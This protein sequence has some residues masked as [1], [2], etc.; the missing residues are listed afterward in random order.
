MIC[1]YRWHVLHSKFIRDERIERLERDSSTIALYSSFDWKADVILFITGYLMNSSLEIQSLSSSAFSLHRWSF[2]VSK[3]ARWFA[4]RMSKKIS[5]T[6]R[7]NWWLHKTS[8]LEHDNETRTNRKMTKR[9]RDRKEK[10]TDDN[11][12]LYRIIIGRFVQSIATRMT[13]L[14]SY[15]MNNVSTVIERI[16]HLADDHHSTRSN[17]EKRATS[18]FVFYHQCFFALV[19]YFDR[20]SA[21][22]VHMLCLV[23]H[24]KRLRKSPRMTATTKKNQCS[25][26]FFVHFDEK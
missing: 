17:E 25:Y 26:R 2:S 20:C 18:V 19:F 23:L 11:S 9:K 21:D 24:R 5:T 10:E 15:S 6:T 4:L 22:R 1:H 13:F 8:V 14:T 12:L 7:T 3:V 16:C